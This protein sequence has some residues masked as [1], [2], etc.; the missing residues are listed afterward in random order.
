[1]TWHLVALVVGDVALVVGSDGWPPDSLSLHYISGAHG[2]R[3]RVGEERRS[4]PRK[5][6]GRGCIVAGACHAGSA[7]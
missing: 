7:T 4:S 3:G 6:C 2:G 1:M 5:G